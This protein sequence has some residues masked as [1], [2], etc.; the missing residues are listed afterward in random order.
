ML[1][2][3]TLTVKVILDKFQT[4]GLNCFD[5]VEMVYNSRKK[6]KKKKELKKD[7]WFD[8]IKKMPVLEII[9]TYIHTYIHEGSKAIVMQS[10]KSRNQQAEAG[11]S[12]EDSLGYALRRQQI[13]IWKNI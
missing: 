1:W 3:K 11:G 10:C 5:T 6:S 8:M 2:Y 7:K 4:K 13:K 12:Q 9:H